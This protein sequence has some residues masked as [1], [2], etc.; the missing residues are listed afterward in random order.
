MLFGIG[1]VFLAFLRSDF[2]GPDLL[3]D[4]Q[5]LD[6]VAVGQIGD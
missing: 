2:A 3:T 1:Y 5:L 6:T 4:Q